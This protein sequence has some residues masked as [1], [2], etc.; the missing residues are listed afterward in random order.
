MGV[1]SASWSNDPEILVDYT[2]GACSPA[3]QGIAAPQPI[4]DIGAATRA[5]ALTG[6]TNYEWYTVTLS[7]DPA[8]LMNTVRVMPSDRLVYMPAVMR[9]PDDF[10][11][12]KN[13]RLPNDR[14]RLLCTTGRPRSKYRI[15]PDSVY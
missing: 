5:Y 14:L 12:R 1:A 11:P 3:A 10:R 15:P 9:G 2:E 7:S 13:D 4:T 6:S 8:G